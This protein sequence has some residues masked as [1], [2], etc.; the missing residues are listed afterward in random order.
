M[1]C[2]RVRVRGG[3]P[4]LALL[5]TL[6]ALGACGGPQGRPPPK[7]YVIRADAMTFSPAVTHLRAGD[8]IVWTNKDVLQHSAT[9]ANGSFDVELPP[10]ATAKTTVTGVGT[11]KFTCRYH[12]GMAGQLQVDP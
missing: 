3:L 9:A 5:G 2:A 6:F 8:V 12:P 10:N 11:I 7:T 4:A 1:T